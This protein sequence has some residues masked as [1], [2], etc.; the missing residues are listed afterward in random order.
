MAQIYHC[1]EHARV[2]PTGFEFAVS[3]EHAVALITDIAKKLEELAPIHICFRAP[4]GIIGIDASKDAYKAAIYR[5]S[6]DMKGLA[7]P[8]NPASMSAAGPG[9]AA[10]EVDRLLHVH[11]KDAVAGAKFAERLISGMVTREDH[12]VFLTSM[13]ELVKLRL[14]VIEAGTVVQDDFG[15]YEWTGAAWVSAESG[16]HHRLESVLQWPR[17]RLRII[18]IESRA[19][20]DA[21]SRSATAQCEAVPSAEMQRMLD[22]NAVLSPAQVARAAGEDP[23]G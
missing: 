3:R 18:E 2:D 22:T 14:H 12:V 16:D 7:P 1:A 17:D 19:E 8:L 20:L 10:T 11:P 23:D 4:N 5:A 9:R 21:S 6:Y 15:M 13:E